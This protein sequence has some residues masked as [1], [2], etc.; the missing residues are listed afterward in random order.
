MKEKRKKG[1][2]IIRLTYASSSSLAETATNATK[3]TT[4]L[5]L[6]MM[7]RFLRLSQNSLLVRLNPKIKT[8]KLPF[9]PKI[10]INIQPHQNEEIVS[11][12]YLNDH[13]LLKYTSTVVVS[14]S[15]KFL[16]L[17]KPSNTV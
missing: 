7:S 1:K 3:R 17:W 4:T 6:I 2:L 12:I 9:L 13:P 8:W 16:V 5:R 11:S 10:A 14:V 15:E